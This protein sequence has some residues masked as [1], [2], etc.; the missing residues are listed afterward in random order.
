M[1]RPQKDLW[2]EGKSWE[3]TDLFQM[4]EFRHTHIH[5]RGSSLG[6]GDFPGRRVHERVKSSDW[7]QTNTQD[8]NFKVARKEPKTVADSNKLTRTL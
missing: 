6:S 5:L 8:A 2:S 3:Q 1:V 7:R 4:F